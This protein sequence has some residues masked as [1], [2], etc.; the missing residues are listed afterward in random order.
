MDVIIMQKQSLP[1]IE[2]V[3]LD[4]PDLKFAES[5]VFYWSAKDQTIYFN[6]KQL[7]RYDGFMKLIHE[8]G[9][10]LC[11][12]KNY[13]SSI[14]L[15]TLEAEAWQKARLIAK[16]YSL[17][18]KDELIEQC[19]DSYRNWLHIRSTCPTCKNVSFETDES[20][21]K[22]FNCHQTWKVPYNQQTRHYRLKL[23]S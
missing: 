22:C 23:T 2:Q 9:H 4:F 11:G 19:L 16:D 12:H 8:I 6:K 17:E 14:E 1:S 10:A 18:I 13:T 20:I 7:V 5:K 15:I 3:R 21:F